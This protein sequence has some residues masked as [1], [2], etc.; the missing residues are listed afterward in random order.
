[1]IFLSLQFFKIS[2]SPE[3]V[4]SLGSPLPCLHNTEC[5]PTKSLFSCISLIFAGCCTLTSA[6]HFV[7][8][9]ED[10]EQ[11]GWDEE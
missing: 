5:F 8:H 4:P 6:L 2:L 3:P 11:L 1:M 7:E 9:L 10:E